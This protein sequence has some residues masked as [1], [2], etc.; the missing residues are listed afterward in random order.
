MEAFKKLLRKLPEKKPYIE[1]LTAALTI[2]VLLTVLILNWNNLKGND[3]KESPKAPE[4]KI[5]VQTPSVKVEKFPTVQT[6]QA[7]CKKE[8]GPIS[9]ESPKE[10]SITNANPVCFSIKYADQNYCSV[11]W[12]YRINNGA[13]SEYNSNSPCVYN[14]PSGN[15]KFELRVQ[16]T[17]SQ[18]TET[19]E[20]NFKYEGFKEAT[21]SAN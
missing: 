10:N 13:W 7:S 6:T 21:Q 16:S 1:V 8:V 5:I 4:S 14:L 9:I 15:T 18:D 3:K 2:P 11:V 17:V 12:S 20:R 19:L